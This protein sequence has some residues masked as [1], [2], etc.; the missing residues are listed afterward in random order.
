[1]KSLV[2]ATRFENTSICAPILLRQGYA[3]LDHQNLHIKLHRYNS[4]L[5]KMQ[6]M[7]TAISGII[8]LS[9]IFFEIFELPSFER[10]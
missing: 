8:V 1:M 6:K 7:R 9:S 5:L 2:N 3:I 10:I 4:D